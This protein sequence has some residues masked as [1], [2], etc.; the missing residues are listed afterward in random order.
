M[1]SKAKAR[2]ARSIVVKTRGR[3]PS[4]LKRQVGG[5]HYRDMPIQ[6]TEFCHRNGI[7]PIESMAILYLCRWRKKG[8]LVDVEKARHALDL[9]IEL[10]QR[11]WKKWPT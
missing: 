1:R 3:P 10:E 6:P 2:R 7:G 4:A 11:N 8:G 5:S 9:L